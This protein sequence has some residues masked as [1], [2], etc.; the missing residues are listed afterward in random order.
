[1]IEQEIKEGDVFDFDYSDAFFENKRK[2]GH[3]HEHWYYRHC[4]DGQ[5][6]AVAVGDQILLRDT[7]WAFWDKEICHFVFSGDSGR[8]F[9]AEEARKNGVLKLQF[10]LTDVEP[11]HNEV[12]D[13][14][15]DSDYFNISYQHGCY[16]CFVLKKGAKKSQA[17]M[18]QAIDSKIADA[19]RDKEMAEWR[20]ERLQTERK[21]IEEG[22]TE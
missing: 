8:A 11:A 4:F 5:L 16:K 12:A 15:D 21:R 3:P 14:Y 22:A 10:N 9:S 6:V 19:A 13:Y 18:L 17:K 7:Y 20:I 2:A 1:M